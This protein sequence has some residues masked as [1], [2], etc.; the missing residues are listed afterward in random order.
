MSTDRQKGILFGL[1]I[2][3][4]NVAIGLN[5]TRPPV[6]LVLRGFVTNQNQFFLR[7]KT[8]PDYICAIIDVTNTGNRTFYCYANTSGHIPGRLE[9]PKAYLASRE[10]G[11]YSDYLNPHSGF[12]FETLVDRNTTNQVSMGFVEFQ[13]SA[14]W[15]FGYLPVGI[16]A[17]L[18]PYLYGSTKEFTMSTKLFTLRGPMQ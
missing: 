15:P 3:A 9:R 18:P 17:K 8:N 11:F 1:A 12:S 4:I 5:T 7:D 10:G 2:F 6:S 14:V 16:Q 13:W